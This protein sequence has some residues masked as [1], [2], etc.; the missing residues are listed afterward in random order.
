MYSTGRI[1]LSYRIFLECGCPGG[2]VSTGRRSDEEAIAEIP[3]IIRFAITTVG[4]K[5]LTG[6][7]AT[8]DSV[9]ERLRN[10]SLEQVMG[11]VARVTLA[12]NAGD[13]G[14]DSSG[15][16][17]QIAGRFLGAEA[18]S[19]LFSL[20]RS[21]QTKGDGR[22]E[23]ALFHERQM[24]NALKLACLSIDFDRKPVNDNPSVLHFVEALLMLNDLI[25]PPEGSMG[26]GTPGGSEAMELYIS[27]NMLFNESP[28]ILE[29]LVRAHF[30]YIEQRP[31]ISGR[32]AVNIPAA[33]A[34]ASGLTSE[35]TWRALY[36][37]YAFWAGSTLEDVDSG[38]IA[39]KRSHYLSTLPMLSQGER[40]VWFSL[41]SWNAADLQAR[42]RRD[43]AM[44]EP[45]YWDVLP[46]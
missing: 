3:A 12:L 37:L 45:R 17:L 15:V 9:L 46:F 4:W 2:N 16:Q 32:G 5:E 10:Y 34:H 11:P 25:D 42:I 31:E 43:Y 40:E 1:R 44:S 41:A 13:D 26:P 36:A 7:N 14:K 21:K 29:D 30:L 27:A 18:A 39:V 24:L 38:A 35:T 33:L 19:S 22:E 23:F 20:I 28:S 8:I 6:R